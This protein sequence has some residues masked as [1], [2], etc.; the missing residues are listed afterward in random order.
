M[1]YTGKT[2]TTFT[3]ITRAADNTTSITSPTAAVD[4]GSNISA[5]ATTITYDTLTTGTGIL[6]LPDQGTIKIGSEQISYTGKTS[7]TLTSLTR[8]INGTTAA[9][10]NNNA[11]TLLQRLA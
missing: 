2:D 4:D 3:G 9:I 5:S 6:A 8:G 1:T 10:H 7:T 11:V